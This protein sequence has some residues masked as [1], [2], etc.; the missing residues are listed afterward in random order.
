MITIKDI[1]LAE[2][3]YHQIKHEIFQIKLVSLFN[4][5][6]AIIIY[7]AINLIRTQITFHRTENLSFYSFYCFFLFCSLYNPPPYGS[8]TVSKNASLQSTYLNSYTS[9]SSMSQ[10]TPYAGYNSGTTTFPN[11]AQNISSATQVTFYFL[12]RKCNIF[13]FHSFS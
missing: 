12:R 9:S 6:A 10:Y 5:W 1:L 8:T 7:Y 4:H 11:V 13:F 3:I 2:G